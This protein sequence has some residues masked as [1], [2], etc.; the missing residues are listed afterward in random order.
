MASVSGSALKGTRKTSSGFR[1][2][3]K[4]DAEKRANKAFNIG[5]KTKATGSGAAPF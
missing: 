3:R 4:S 2:P 1:T 5:K